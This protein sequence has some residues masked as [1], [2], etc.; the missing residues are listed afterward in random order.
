MVTTVEGFPHDTLHTELRADIEPSSIGVNAPR[1]T[2]TVRW[3]VSDPTVPVRFTFHYSDENG[4]DCG[5]HHH[6]Q[7]HVAEL[8]HYQQRTAEGYTYEEFHFGS[9]EPSRVVWEV[10]EELQ[11]VLIE[12]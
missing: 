1:G 7:D 11:T 2:L 9:K 8:G 12:R 3:F 4:F 6:E 10:L 5:W